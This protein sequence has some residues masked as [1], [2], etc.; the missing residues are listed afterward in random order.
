MGVETV[1]IA[2]ALANAG[3]QIYGASQQAK[4]NKANLNA[5]QQNRADL[6]QRIDA[7][8]QNGQNPYAAQ[9]QQM[10]AGMRPPGQNQV[11]MS[12]FS[13]PANYSTRTPQA[14]SPDG[15][16]TANPSSINLESLLAG[17]QMWQFNPGQAP[18]YNPSQLDNAPQVSAPQIDLNTVTGTQGQNAGQD[19]LLQMMNRDV[20]G[21]PD[22]FLKQ[23][24]QQ[25]GGGDTQFDTSELYKSLNAVNQRGL[26]EQIAQMKGSKGSFA[27]LFSSK[28]DKQEGQMRE[29]FAQNMALANNQLAQQSF[30]NAQN[31]RAPALGQL[32]GL[33][34]FYGQQPFQN[35]AL[36]L[37]AAQSAAGLGQQNSAQLLQALMANQSAGLQ[38]GLAN[39]GLAGQYGLANQN[40]LNQAGQ[41]NAGMNFN[42]QQLN[43][44]QGN[45]YNQLVMSMMGQA[46]GAQQS[47]NQL[48]A[49]LLGILGGIGVPQQQAS[50]VPGAIADASETAMMLP[51]LLQM[52]NNNRQGNNQYGPRGY[53]SGIFNQ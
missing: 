36:Q 46:Q 44:Q 35:A 8:M 6:T 50:P 31:R 49:Q 7:Q 29:N 20:G 18:S 1:L 37:Q 10:M 33:D 3:S 32:A 39:Q 22:A 13:G 42:N 38:A 26:D 47:Q 23:Q 21:G 51:F 9:L 16:N 24:L 19:A 2:S 28:T 11:G 40:A 52:Y 48:N 30:E 15:I 12:P 14:G 25:I 27:N 17:P 34:Q 43:A 5:Q 41:F 45:I 53:Q 4:A